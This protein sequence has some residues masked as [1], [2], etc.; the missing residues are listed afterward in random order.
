MAAHTIQVHDAIQQAGQCTA[1]LHNGGAAVEA[2]A[3][4]VGA[5]VGWPSEL[6]LL[7]HPIVE[8]HLNY[9]PPPGFASHKVFTGEQQA[10]DRSCH[11][12]MANAAK[13]QR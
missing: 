2:R 8:N 9:L 13:P 1:T 4:V 3:I 11:G 12:L 6:L 7:Q 5:T 10:H